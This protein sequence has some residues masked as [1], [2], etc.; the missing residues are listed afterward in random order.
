M[1]FKG[2]TAVNKIK[3]KELI[4]EQIATP[5]IREEMPETRSPQQNRRIDSCH[6]RN[7]LRVLPFA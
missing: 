3:M 7:N 5:K 1:T 4:Y 6:F 2:F